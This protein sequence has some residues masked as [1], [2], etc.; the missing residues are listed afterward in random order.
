MSEPHRDHAIRLLASG[1]AKRVPTEHDLRLAADIVDAISA[2]DVETFKAL[3]KAEAK[4]E[5][6]KR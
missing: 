2:H 6:A 5:E 3:V 4:L 1:L